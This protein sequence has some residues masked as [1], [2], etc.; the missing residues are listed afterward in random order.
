MTDAKPPRPRR[1]RS[2]VEN[3]GA[4]VLG[5]ES[6]VV[7]L[8][9]LVAFGLNAL[10]AGIPSW[11]GIVAG[12]VL[13]VVMVLTAGVLRHRWGIA[14]GWALQALVAL[15]ALVV[16]AMLLIAL[17]FGGLWAYAT[18]GGARVQARVA[19]AAAAAQGDPA[20][21]GPADIADPADAAPADSDPA[22]TPER[23]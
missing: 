17:I 12:S 11:W 2:L 7:F 21:P 23:E 5:F 19:A 9:G 14:L 15:S 22:P 4:I 6:V 20:D 10:P 16:P 18:I 3:L 13:A 8:G 1:Q